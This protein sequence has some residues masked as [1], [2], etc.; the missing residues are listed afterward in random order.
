M[1]IR[2]LLRRN[3]A[4]YWRGNLAVVAGVAT[5]AA[6]LAGALMVG[7]SV[8][9]S[10]RDLVLMRLG[11]AETVVA[12]TGLFRDQLAAA[13]GEACPLI[14]MEGLVT[15]QQSGRR[16]SRVKV[17]GIDE[18]FWRFHGSGERGPEG[19]GAIAG[20]ALADEL[21]AREG[22]TILLRLEKP[23]DIHAESMMG[24]KDD[25]ARTIRLTLRSL[26]PAARLGEFSLA[27]QQGP[28]LALF[29]PLALLEKELDQPGQVN[30][31][32][33]RGDAAAAGKSL[34][35]SF[36]LE[37]VGVRA[38]RLDPGALQV[39]TAAAV[40]PDSLAE[41][42]R[43]EAARSSLRT[44]PVLT[45][46]A[47]SIRAGERQIP[48]SLVAALDLTAVRP[49]ALPPTK[50]KP[51]VLNQWAASDL[52]V[53]PGAK[54]TLDYY[55]WT[56]D[57]RLVTQSSE[58]ELAA[59]VPIAGLAADRR[60]APDYPGIT[61]SD[62]V[63]NWDPPFPMNLRLV[64]PKDED[65]WDQYRA[66]PKAFIALEDGQRLWESRFGKLTA[67]RLPLAPAEF[68]TAL[69]ERLDPLRMGFT[70]TEA[71][72][73]GL[74]A[75]QGATDFGEY[76]VYFSFFL[77]VSA[78]LLAG[79]FFRLGVEQRMREIGLLEAVG[80]SSA[81]VTKLFLGE[82]LLL[83]AAGS[84]LGA[85]GS[86]AYAGVI[87]LG[88]GTWW[89]DAVG[90]NRLALHV[91]AVPLIAG[92]A[93]SILAAAAAIAVTFRGLRKAT[94]RYLL[95]G[96]L[97]ESQ[98]GQTGKTSQSLRASVVLAL[99]AL[100]LV[101]AAATGVVPQA[102][103]FFGAGTLLLVSAL[104][105]MKARLTASQLGGVSG[106]GVAALSRLAL[107]NAGIRPGRTVL[108]AA[109]IASAAFIVVSVEAFR[110]RGGESLLEAKSGSGGYPLLAESLLPIYHNPNSAS[111]RESLNLTEMP[112]VKFVPM[113]LRPGD[114]ASCL[115][116]YQPKNPRILS[117]PAE[118][119]RERRFSFASALSPADIPWSLLETDPGG[120]IPAIADANS[121]TYVLHKKLGEEIEI[122]TPAGGTARL[123][124]VAALAD[125]I[126]QSELI[127]SE[128]NFLRLF[129][130][131]Q[132][133]R[134]FLIEAPPGQAAQVTGQIEEALA[135]YGFDAV[136]TAE[137][138]A[139]FHRVENTY[140]STFQ[141]LGGF[142]LLLGTVGLAAILV[143]NVLE[144]RRELALLLALG[145]RTGSLA[146]LI[147]VE[148]VFML[149]CGLG[150]GTLAALVA[151]APALFTRGG[152]LPAL[153]LAV[154]LGAVLLAGVLASLAAT[155][156]ALRLPLLASLR[157]E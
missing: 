155:R 100:A 98:S 146:T 131:Q 114:D 21:A 76:F 75:A 120:A 121:M 27:A 31:I 113:R 124:L 41:T 43:A 37:D 142:G 34:A 40:I 149:V 102:G 72:R 129:P 54:I 56:S 20:E 4:Y 7:A 16:A 147:L 148:H 84:L 135:D 13:F 60:L 130:D 51:I 80:F 157:S 151:I 63:N 133:H 128:R 68:S 8:R 126:F 123:R 9:A 108:C 105:W 97:A 36:A 119:L 29:V 10:L 118:F 28:V 107:R 35:A 94:P 82:G 96:G 32:L 127:I 85:A 5:A 18:R 90:T 89:S 134:V 50:A 39:E 38:R 22:E 83:A 24:R 139:A 45:Y 79:L 6:V 77:V 140:L 23:S 116:L 69:R 15:H 95:S 86:V 74:E 52:G 111:G 14:A 156:V 141:T 55:L 44:L 122:A 30:T 61:D 109:L 58:F 153:S 112:G 137:R 12:S 46:L 99:V 57:S 67:I 3:L 138:L 101:G 2:T 117:A 88:L 81:R 47:N 49:A 91:S 144:R 106:H 17:Y 65:Y 70:I 1:R 115:N 87:L 132:G 78:L 62:D 73:L 26:L 136:S 154:L 33:T 25:A 71:R 53:A 125:S 143:R 66:T 48:Y 110:R 103:G 11:R 59:V 64:R 104:T 152:A 93:G 42:V 150:A 19:R 145:Y 92:I